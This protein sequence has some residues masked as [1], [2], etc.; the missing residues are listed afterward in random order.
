MGF[1]V[2]NTIQEH[3]L[4]TSRDLKTALY[5]YKPNKPQKPHNVV[6]TGGNSLKLLLIHVQPANIH[7]QPLKCQNHAHIL[8]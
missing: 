1:K 2:F 4:Y 5:L 3:I 8:F 6:K 7:V